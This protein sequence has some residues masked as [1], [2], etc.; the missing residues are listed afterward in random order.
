[1]KKITFLLAIAIIP[2]MLLSCGKENKKNTDNME[3]KSDTSTVKKTEL[4][5]AGENI[6]TVEFKCDGMTCTG[7]EKTITKSVTKLDGIKDIIADHKTKSV[8]VAFDSTRSDVTA[9]E[10]AINDVKYK[11]ERI[12]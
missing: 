5:T 11:T 2:L 6:S 4:N 9:I 12:K 3:M 7:C 10:K 1:M 8:K